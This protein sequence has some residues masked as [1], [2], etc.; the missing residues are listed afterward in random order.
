MTSERDN[1][2][3]FTDDDVERF[4]KFLNLIGT[5]MSFDAG[6]RLADIPSVYKELAWVQTKLIPMME[7]NVLEVV[8][9]SRGNKDESKD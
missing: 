2:M 7:A 6:M 4:K 3:N 1:I 9:H 5:K 8:A